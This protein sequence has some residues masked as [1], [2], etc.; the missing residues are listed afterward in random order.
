MVPDATFPMRSTRSQWLPTSRGSLWKSKPG[1]P[2]ILGF[3]CCQNSHLNNG[4][5]LISFSLKYPLYCDLLAGCSSAFRHV[6]HTTPCNSISAQRYVKLFFL[7]YSFGVKVTVIN[8]LPHCRV[9]W[10]NEAALLTTWRH[11][12]YKKKKPQE[13]L[14]VP[15]CLILLLLLL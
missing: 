8:V 2:G 13:W 7:K 15:A 1:S 5:S 12:G 6:C 4:I 9:V 10:R 11:S 3:F 14:K